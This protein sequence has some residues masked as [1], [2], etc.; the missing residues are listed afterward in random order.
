[1]TLPFPGARI[2]VSAAAGALLCAVTLQPRAAGKTTDA[3]PEITA[4]EKSLR[5]VEQDP[6]ADLV[7]L[8]NERHGKILKR[9][10]D[11]VNVL[12]YHWRAKVLADTAKRYAEIH[13]PGGKYSRISNIRARTIKPDGTVVPVDPG[14]IFE[15]VARLGTSYKV[16]E[17][18]FTFPAVEKGAILEYKYD[19][20]DNSMIYLDPFYLEGSGFTLRAKLTQAIP[21]ETGYQ[22]LCSKC[23]PGAQPTVK[24]WRDGPAKGRLYELE[25]ADLAGYHDEVLMPPRRDVS[26]HLEMVLQ[27]W[28]NIYFESLGRQDRVL[29]DWD[30]VAKYTEFWYKA[31][32]KDGIPALRSMVNGWLEGI[33]DPQEKIKAIVRHVQNDFRYVS[34][35]NVV[36]GTRILAAIVKD[37]TADNEEK[38]VVLAAALKIAGID[39]DFALVS[40]K[41]VGSSINPDFFSL[42]QFTHA[43]V[44]LPK[45]DGTHEWIDPTVSCAPYGFVPWKDSG[46]KALLI[47][48]GLG[49][50]VDLPTR[51]EASRTSYRV[52]VTPGDGGRAELDIEAEFAGEDGVEMRAELAPSAEGARAE[53]LGDWL[54]ARLPGATFLGH[55][56]ENIG[57]FDEPLKISIQASAMG[58]VTTADD[59]T[60]VRGCILS[61]KES[62]PIL[63]TD[64]R[65]P[66]SVDRGWNIQET[67]LIEPPAG[68]K[69]AGLPGPTQADAGVAKISFQC[70]PEGEGGARCLRVFSAPRKQ[71]PPSMIE[72][73][74]K[75]YDQI[76]QVD[77]T[78]V[79]FQRPDAAGP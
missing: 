17:W 30:A 56:I 41:D 76:V 25:L 35:Q 11:W 24:P 28:K 46:A 72:R 14:Q 45:P 42:S 2:V 9:A 78:V 39:S 8:N 44:A 43:I 59:V 71:W 57:D 21:D 75:I 32:S 34:Y 65:Y 51:L 70:F 6:Q 26:P 47:K 49:R 29:T 13:I 61:A 54:E 1:M 60:M 50:L 79:A 12:D 68:M 3:W 52:E 66:L 23:P 77:R 38:A 31:A 16:S 18:V 20:H 48:G 22:I 27:T 37:M 58:I 19:R 55:K 7:I 62:N 10:D 5:A 40:G 4:A 67:V 33:T 15:K 64:R 74:R 53:F 73:L 63:R 36:G 69:R